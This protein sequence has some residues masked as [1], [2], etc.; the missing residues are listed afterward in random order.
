MPTNFW[1]DLGEISTESQLRYIG[2]PAPDA[3]EGDLGEEQQSIN[4]K[5]LVIISLISCEENT[6]HNKIMKNKKRKKKKK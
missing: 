2:E 3:K 5:L 6:K 4:D 1:A